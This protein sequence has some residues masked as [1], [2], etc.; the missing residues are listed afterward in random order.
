MQFYS[1]NIIKPP[2]SRVKYEQKSDL[3]ID[4]KIINFIF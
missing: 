2:D 1:T 4:F 3:I